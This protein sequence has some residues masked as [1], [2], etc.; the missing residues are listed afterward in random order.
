MKDFIGEYKIDVGICKQFIYL[1]ES[2]PDKHFSGKITGYHGTNVDKEKSDFKKSVE[3]EYN[4]FS[5]LPIVS[6]YIE[7]LQKCLDKYIEEYPEVEIIPK[8]YP[9][10]PRVQRYDKN[11]H[12]KKWH[13]ERCGGYTQKRCLTYMTYLNDVE[14]GGKTE[15]KFQNK[16]FKPEIG[17][18]LIWPADW[19][20][21]HRGFG[22]SGDGYKYIATGW[23]L[24]YD[25]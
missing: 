2:H 23:Y 1:F 21:T 24:H 18:T 17:K 4:Q 14:S 25:E 3:L 10:W 6:G 5:N 20:H 9:S 11:G 12:F 16:E 13:F 15:F 8:F 19:T 22:P 7:E